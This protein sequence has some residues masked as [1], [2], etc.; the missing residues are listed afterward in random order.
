VAALLLAAYSAARHTKA[1][2]VAHTRA[3]TDIHGAAAMRVRRR[4]RGRF[5]RLKRR[6]LRHW[7]LHT[8]LR[9]WSRYK[10]SATYQARLRALRKRRATGRALH[11]SPRAS[12]P[13]SPAIRIPAASNAS[14]IKRREYSKLQVICVEPATRRQL[15]LTLGNRSDYI[16]QDLEQAADL[17]VWRIML[18]DGIG[19]F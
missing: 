12:R 16:G 3:E 2:R 19:L 10:H 8:S 5:L 6:G 13:D 1:E 17:D 11:I 14:H 4:R 9:R 15:F 18:I 7:R